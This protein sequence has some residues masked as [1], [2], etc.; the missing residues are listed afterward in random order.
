MKKPR[1]EDALIERIERVFPGGGPLLLGPGDDAA[2]LKV[3]P[4]RRLVATVDEMCEGAHF[5][6]SF[7]SPELIAGKL[8]RM[9]LS[10]LAAMGE[11]RPL[12]LLTAAGLPRSAS[13]GW[14]RRFIKALRAEA[15]RS[16]VA[17]AGGNIARS[18][19]KHF[20][21]T[22]LGECRG[23]VTRYGA[24]PGDLV[25]SLGPL[26]RSRAGLELLMSK[27]ARRRGFAGLVDA[28]WR[29][30]PM[31]AE[32]ALIGRRGLAS[33]MLDNSD[34]LY[35]SLG[36][37][38][39]LSGCRVKARLPEEACSP[40]LRRWAAAKKKDW[41]LYALAGG[42]DYGLVFSCRPSKEALVRRLLPGAL[43]VGEALKGRG[44]EVEGYDGE[45]PVFEHF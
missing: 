13:G 3:R 29:P 26:G 24:R 42:E 31:L 44:V 10:D 38:A 23:F 14:A 18:D 27:G 9:N 8:L 12:A 43:R 35:R 19:K 5:L 21:M 40:D 22:V 36:I 17:V 7:S 4:G 28:F 20:S 41:R 34:G 15:R 16:G 1:G 6:D 2:V 37:I 11:V 33:A 45:I 32:G 25:Y 39:R 30:R